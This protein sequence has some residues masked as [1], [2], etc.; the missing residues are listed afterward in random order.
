[1]LLV[2][3]RLSEINLSQQ[4]DFYPLVRSRESTVTSCQQLEVYSGRVIVAGVHLPRQKQWVCKSSR[5]KLD[6]TYSACGDFYS[7]QQCLSFGFASSPKGNKNIITLKSILPKK[8]KCHVKTET[9]NSLAWGEKGAK[10]VGL[11]VA[12]TVNRN[13]CNMWR[14]LDFCWLGV[15]KIGGRCISY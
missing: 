8:L 12:L 13:G 10:H 11:C 4:F 3:T 5:S 14:L 7:F 9:H 2:C 6:I 15:G 1:M